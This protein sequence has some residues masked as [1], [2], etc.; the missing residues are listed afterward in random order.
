VGFDHKERLALFHPNSSAPI[1][2]Q[3]SRVDPTD[4]CHPG[5]SLHDIDFRVIKT[6]VQNI[7]ENSKILAA[8]SYAPVAPWAIEQQ[9]RTQVV[10]MQL[11][12]HTLQLGGVMAQIP[13]AKVYVGDC[14][15][16]SSITRGGEEMHAPPRRVVARC[17]QQLPAVGKKG[18]PFLD[19]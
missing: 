19:G 14:L 16:P 3:G 6:F 8:A 15:A 18:I 1:V 10:I 12:A 4:Y 9:Q 13:F 7:R 17:C 2:A 5:A 11:H